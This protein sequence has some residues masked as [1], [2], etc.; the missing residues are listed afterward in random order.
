MDGPR[1]CYAKLVRQRQILYDI[2]HVWNLK[3]QS[4]RTNKK[5]ETDR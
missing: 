3:K 5:T 4:K 1:G 2:T